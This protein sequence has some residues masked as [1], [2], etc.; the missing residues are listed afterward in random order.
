MLQT[1][2]MPPASDIGMMFVEAVGEASSMS[3]SSGK[4]CVTP[5]I[6]TLTS[7]I[8]P[9][10]PV[11]TQ[12][13]GYGVAGPESGVVIAPPVQLAP[14]GGG[15]GGGGWGGGEGAGTACQSG[16]RSSTMML[17]ASLIWW[18]PSAFML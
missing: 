16:S 10:S 15:G 4:A 8:V 7:V 3:M 18:L 17:P 2:Y 6:T 11:T 5:L 14:G 12:V 13:D 9:E 1:G